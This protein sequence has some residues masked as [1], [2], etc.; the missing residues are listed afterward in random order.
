MKRPELKNYGLQR[1]LIM[2]L[3]QAHT[4]ITTGSFSKVRSTQ[5]GTTEGGGTITAQRWM[6]CRENFHEISKCTTRFLF[7]HPKHKGYCIASFFNEIEDL[8]NVKKRSFFG[9]TQRKTI[10][11]VKMSEWWKPQMKR[12]LFTAFLRCGANFRWNNE[13][14]IEAVCDAIESTKYTRDTMNAILRFLE[15]N[16]RYTGNVNGWYT[17]FKKF[18]PTEEEIKKLLV[19]PGRKH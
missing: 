16:T 3:A 15:G 13:N 12:S 17:Q 18:E 1:N 11:W 19:A 7:S 14:N 8:L 4:R 2:P 10:T 5:G 9:P 6:Y